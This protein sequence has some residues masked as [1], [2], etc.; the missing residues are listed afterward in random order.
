MSE[1][2]IIG[3]GT[4]IDKLA[5]ELLER[6]KKL[7][8]NLDLIRVE[9]G[10]G[11][12]GIPHIGSLGDAV[13]AYGVK[14]ALENLG[15]KS[16]LIAYSDDLDG[17]RKIPEGLPD[18]LNEHLAKP[19][20]LIPDPFGCHDSYGMHMSSILLDGLD[21]VG[22]NYEFRRAVDTYKKG[23]LKDQIHT[24]LENSKKIGE[25]IS[26]L[27]GQEKFQ[28]YLP[29]FPVCSNCSRL[30]TAEAFEYLSNEKKVRYKCHDAQ[31]GSQTIK[32]CGHD[33][34]ADITKDLGKLAWK[35][36]FAARWTAFDIR[37]EAYGKDIM[38]S[39]KVN[40]WVA[41]EILGFPHPHHVKY[42]MFLDKG[43]KKISK[44]LGNVLTAQKWL[45]F[46]TPKSILLLLYKRITG[47]RELGIEDIPSL[48]NE[49]NELEDIYF[50]KIK[51]DNEAKKIKSKGLYEYVNLLNPPKQQSTH[52]NYRLLV[53][54]SKIFKENRIERVVK[55][56]QDYGVIKNS[57]KQIE[58][59]IN[60][61]GNFADTFD[62][63]EKTDVEIDSS[64]KTALKD[65]IQSLNAESEPEDLQNLIY[66]TAKNNN[67][68]PRDF[69]KILYQIILGTTRGPKIGP[70]ISDIGRKQ[71]AKTI[72][73]Y[74]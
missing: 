4:W 49:Y 66:Q 5:Y 62:E 28:K 50:G 10:L 22:I 70:F 48:M 47:A 72:S 1:Q 18:S 16:E 32:G 33:G 69:F 52:I 25:K 8:R 73:E 13:R 39:V 74:V 71:V 7:G 46:G 29:Y 26:D 27:V 41:D 24:I 34:E 55:K 54:L 42:E 17:L 43:G 68:Q 64:T 14:L 57:D 60:L 9:S 15:Y 67:V 3:K 20:S 30:Y 63:K 11:A 45:E 59:L 40:D 21:K 35:V 38:D 44:S 61:A 37:F 53:E 23:L 51:L 6:E 12:S 65:L 2:K 58:E 36:E 19:V 31:I 56:L